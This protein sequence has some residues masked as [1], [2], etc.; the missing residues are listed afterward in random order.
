MS[1]I[2]SLL[3]AADQVK[4]PNIQNCLAGDHNENYLDVDQA[5]HAELAPVVLN[6]ATVKSIVEY[7]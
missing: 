2:V 6:I 1:G 7:N 3:R 5:H 4:S